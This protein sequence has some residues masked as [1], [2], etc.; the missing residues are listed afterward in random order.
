MKLG[1]VVKLKRPKLYQQD[2]VDVVGFIVEYFPRR[3]CSTGLDRNHVCRVS[4]P[5]GSIDKTW[6]LVRELEVISEAG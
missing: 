4:W 5:G 1:D 2:L 3:G 6:R